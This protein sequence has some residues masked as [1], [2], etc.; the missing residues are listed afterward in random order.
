MDVPLNVEVRCAEG[1]C[2]RS[3]SIILNP[4]TNQVTHVVVKFEG[5]EYMV[6]LDYIVESTPQQIQLRLTKV[7]MEQLEPFD[8]SRFLARD[9]APSPQGSEAAAEESG[10]SLW[11]YVALGRDYAE[12][13]DQAGQMAY[14]ELCVRRGAR[15]EASDGSIG[16]VE[17]FLVN[18]I[19]NLIT[20]LVLREGPVWEP[21]GITVPISEI[22]RIEEETVFL[23]IDKNSV[24]TLPAVPVGPRFWKFLP[25]TTQP[26]P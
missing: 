1:T 17:E 26:R 9:P 5:Q 23:K 4:I 19:N 21:K 13:M 8:K 25:G 20:H 7:D 2:G 14:E 16:R 12:Q 10:T 6:P 11:P 15:V 22:D 18:P 24:R 3:T